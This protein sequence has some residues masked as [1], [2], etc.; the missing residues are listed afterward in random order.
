MWHQ[1]YSKIFNKSSRSNFV[2]FGRKNISFE[3]AQKHFS[4][5]GS[6]CGLKKHILVNDM[7][8]QLS[9]LAKQKLVNGLLINYT[10]VESHENF[11][12][13][14]VYNFNPSHAQS[15]WKGELTAWDLSKDIVSY[16]DSEWLARRLID[17]K[18]GGINI[19]WNDLK[20]KILTEVINLF[21]DCS[22]NFWT[23]RDLLLVFHAAHTFQKF[24]DKLPG[25]SEKIN[26]FSFLNGYDLKTIQYLLEADLNKFTSVAS[27][28]E[29]AEHKLSLKG[30]LKDGGIITLCSNFVEYCSSYSVLDCVIWEAALNSILAQASESA[31]TN[32][33]IVQDLLSINTDILADFIVTARQYRTSVITGVEQN[34]LDWNNLSKTHAQR[35]IANSYYLAVLGAAYDGFAEWIAGKLLNDYQYKKEILQMANEFQ[36]MEDKPIR[37]IYRGREVYRNVYSYKKIQKLKEHN[38]SSQGT[39][40][41]RTQS[42]EILQPWNESDRTRLNLDWL[43]IGEQKF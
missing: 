20:I 22:G 10:Y 34:I 13:Q 33:V 40:R 6:G 2:E 24:L 8:N 15:N 3:E 17:F 25:L 42:Q 30:W 23:L 26:P 29:T 36:F 43:P 18:P 16:K 4:I 12:D 11:F 21:I 38:K 35:I 32:F 1:I 5:I 7:I 41:T 28:W 14:T 27:Q 31:K 19:L 37:G 39:I 9:K